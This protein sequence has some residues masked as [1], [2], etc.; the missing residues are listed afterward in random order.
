MIESKGGIT[1]GLGVLRKGHPKHMRAGLQ[2]SHV[3]SI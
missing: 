1:L 2:K 3:N